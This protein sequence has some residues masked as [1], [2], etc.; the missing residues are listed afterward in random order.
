MLEPSSE[1]EKPDMPAKWSWIYQQIGTGS[2][3]HMTH[4]ENKRIVY[5]KIWI[6][7]A[8]VYNIHIYIYYVYMWFDKR[9]TV[10]GSSLAEGCDD[11]NIMVPDIVMQQQHKWYGF[12]WTQDILIIWLIR[13]WSSLS[14]LQTMAIPG[15]PKGAHVRFHTAGGNPA[16]GWACSTAR[17]SIDP[18]WAPPKWSRTLRAAAALIGLYKEVVCNQDIV[19][20]K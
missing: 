2:H 6:G 10:L 4:Y 5:N 11:G 9:K 18:K 16:P 20:P 12:V 1:W 8:M 17:A 13:S 19:S 14:V 7:L 3:T 15:S